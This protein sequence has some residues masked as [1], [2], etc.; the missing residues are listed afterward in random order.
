MINWEKSGWHPVLN[1][2]LIHCQQADAINFKEE[3]VVYL[4]RLYFIILSRILKQFH[5]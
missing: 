5:I 4:Q 1:H 3:T 2:V